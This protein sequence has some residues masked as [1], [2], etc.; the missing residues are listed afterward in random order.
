M[1]TDPPPTPRPIFFPALSSPLRS[2]TRRFPARPRPT[3]F[4]PVRENRWTRTWPPRPLPKYRPRAWWSAS[5]TRRSIRTAPSSLL[6]P[7]LMTSL[8][9]RRTPSRKPLRC[10]LRRTAA[11]AAAA[12]AA[13]VPRPTTSPWFRRMASRPPQR[14]SPRRKRMGHSL[15]YVPQ[16][17]ALS[18]PL[19][20]PALLPPLPLFGEEKKKD[21]KNSMDTHR[22]RPPPFLSAGDEAHTGRG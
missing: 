13:A 1:A 2:L 10:R 9:N 4:K 19:I 5:R 20:T 3:P 6:P 15:K 18:P 17:G 12:A 11:A 21:K 8:W 22:R 14:V 16:L 7:P